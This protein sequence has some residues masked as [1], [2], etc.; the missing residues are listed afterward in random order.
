MHG[1]PIGPMEHRVTNLEASV[2]RIDRAVERISDSIEKISNALS[3]QRANADSLARSWRAVEDHEQRLRSV[4]TDMPTLR[5]IRNW[6][7]A[8]VL[9]T[10]TL[11]GL[12]AWRTLFGAN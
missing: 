3:H 2:E 11:T 10:L 9:G 6:V 8:G 5:L 4:E 7:V 12:A 1:Y